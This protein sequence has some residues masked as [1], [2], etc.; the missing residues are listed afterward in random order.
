MELEAEKDRR[1]VEIEEMM[2]QFGEKESTRKREKLTAATLASNIKKE[3]NAKN[4]P[5]SLSS[6][7]RKKRK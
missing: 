4:Y 2:I 6:H 5:P 7:K 3:P 1:K